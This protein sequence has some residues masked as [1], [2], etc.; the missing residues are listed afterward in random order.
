MHIRDRIKELCRV[1]AADLK[2]NPKNWRSHPQR[3]RDAL[4]GILAE[5]GYADALLTRELPDGT[6]EI[7]DGHL[8]AETTPETEVPVLVLDVSSEEADKILATH[9]PLAEMADQDEKQ[10]TKLVELVKT[11][12]KAVAKMLSGLV[13]DAQAMAARREP[14]PAEVSVVETFQIIVQCDGEPQQ[15]EVY[16]RLTG[17]GYNCRVLTL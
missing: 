10:L 7:I 11:E 3:Q 15:R 5:V 13:D 17:E 12:D 14:L 8:R 4:L 9:D 1:K 6:L 16:E 2:P